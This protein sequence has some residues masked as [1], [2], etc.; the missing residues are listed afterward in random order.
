MLENSE[1][2][3][4]R[5][6]V[7]TINYNSAEY[8]LKAIDSFIKNH[9]GLLY[10][11][12]VVDN[13]SLKDD[14]EK[15]LKNIQQINTNNNIIIIRSNNNLG[16]SKGNNLGLKYAYDNY[17]FDYL[18]LMNND[19]I[20]HTKG[21]LNKMIYDIEKKGSIYVAEMPLINNIKQK[22]EAEKQIQ[23]RKIPN[24]FSLF[25]VSS[26]ILNRIFFPVKNNFIYKSKMP[27]KNDVDAY[28]LSGA[29]MLLSKRFINMI[30]YF[31][32]DTFLYGE[33]IIIGYQIK[34]YGYKGFLN[35]KYIVDH[36]QGA[37]SE[38]KS[39]SGFTF[40]HK[41]KSASIFAKKYLKAKKYYLFFFKVKFI[42]E[43]FV[44]D[45]LINKSIKEFLI[46]YKLLKKL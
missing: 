18:L 28:V 40:F 23:I 2:L 9:Q 21:L 29:F 12:I 3:R 15:L 8:T 34:K 37:S 1:K 26:P 31:D 45:M 42:I 14:Y 11:L 17:I 30:K 38:K 36:V 24:L 16:F 39:F 32:V 33:E 7:I 43:A 22:K 5:L 19:I 35:T 20:I 10:K 44:L 6:I 41:Y 27:F 13:N 25:I 4:V 46:F